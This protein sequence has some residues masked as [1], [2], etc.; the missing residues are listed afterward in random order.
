MGPKRMSR[1]KVKNFG[2]IKEGYL[3]NDGWLDVKKVTVFIGNQ[4]TGK[5]TLAKLISTFSWMEKALVRGDHD[6]SWFEGTDK[7]RSGYLD[8][9][10]LESYFRSNGGGDSLIEY[11]GEAY[12]FR[13]IGGELTVTESTGNHYP[14]PQIM[15][16]PA[17][18]NFIAYVKSP[19][20]LRLS[21]GAL[22]EFLAA[23]ERAKEEMRGLVH[24]P[25]DDVAVEYDKNSDVLNLHG[26]DF[27][28]KLTDASSGFQ[29][30]VP[31][32][33]V[34][35]YLANSVRRQ[36]ESNQESMTSEERDR[37]KK[38]F[39]EIWGNESLS[40]DQKR[41]ALSV[42]TSKFNKTVFV[43][44]VEEPEQNLF[45]TSQRQML[46]SLLEF[47]NLN[48]GNKLIMT[49]HSPY[50]INFLNIAIQGQYLKEAIAAS[51]SKDL[52]GRLDEIV[53]LQSLV[54]GDAVAVYEMDDANGR[55][56]RLPSPLG[57]PS[58]Q[59]YLNSLLREGN[60]LFDALLEL[61]EE[62]P[63]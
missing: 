14:L 52:M 56:H 29:S 32:Y 50:I 22:L 43:N 4:G 2:P 41:V 5:S 12:A 57:I 44:I 6:K 49:T 35:A 13:F 40:E 38:G 60:R 58:D 63:R 24:L 33:L 34:S 11:Q 17:E 54:A 28:V 27:K 62:L 7:L 20:E 15:Y 48:P 1:I 46:H 18:R 26:K 37:F 3:E 42:L 59:N 55:I 21:S 47:N 19:K 30:L 23:F 9:H 45:P 36:S 39:E 53:P 8:F 25:I 61:E 51:G 16:V 10:R 31:L